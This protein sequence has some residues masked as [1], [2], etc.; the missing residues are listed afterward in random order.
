MSNPR[1]D[2][3]LQEMR[4]V[5]PRASGPAISMPSGLR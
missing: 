2:Y 1:I 5:D 3:L 4:C